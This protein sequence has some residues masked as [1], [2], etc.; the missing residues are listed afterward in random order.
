MLNCVMTRYL[1]TDLFTYVLTYSIEQ[2]PSWQ[3]IRFSTSQEFSRILW[4]LK[5]HYRIYKSPASVPILSQI[6]PV[7]VPP[8]YFQKIHLNIIV[9]STS[10]SSKLSLT[11]VSQPKPCIYLSSPHMC[12]TPSPSHSSRFNHPN[13]TWWA[14]QIIKLLI[15]WFS[16]LPCYLIPLRPKYSPQ[17]PIFKH[18]QPLWPVNGR[19]VS[20]R[21]IDTN[22]QLL[23]TL[24]Y[25]ENST[26][27]NDKKHKSDRSFPE[28]DS[29]GTHEECSE[30]V[31]V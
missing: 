5:V 1:L 25:A 12:Y 14:V 10:G 19:R 23:Q 11:Q 4:N 29:N 30:E 16:R 17:H 6:N 24:T 2:N 22:K 28:I 13:N 26:L 31:S 21:H 18:P 9:P 8:L 15:I 7:H 3:V 27:L 20:V